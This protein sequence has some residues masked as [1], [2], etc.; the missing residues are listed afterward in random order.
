MLYI[1]NREKEILNMKKYHKM[2]ILTLVLVCIMSRVM[3]VRFE[4]RTNIEA[5]EERLPMYLMTEMPE[6]LYA[7]AE[8]SMKKEKI[9]W[10]TFGTAQEL[11]D[12]IVGKERAGKQ[13]EWVYYQ[14]ELQEDFHAL[15]LYH[16]LRRYER[17]AHPICAV[18]CAKGLF[19]RFSQKMERELIVKKNHLYGLVCSASSLRAMDSDDVQRLLD[20]FV[21]Y[22]QKWETNYLTGS[23]LDEE[24]LYWL[25]HD[26]RKTTYDKPKRTFTEMRAT[27]ADWRSRDVKTQKFGMLQKAEYEIAFPGKDAGLGI[28]FHYAEIIPETGYE[29]YLADYVCA[30]ENYV[31]RVTDLQT[32]R[33]IQI[34]DANLC[35]N[36]LDTVNF[37]DV[38]GDGYPDMIITR[39]V[40]FRD[41][42]QDGEAFENAVCILWNP[43]ENNFETGTKKQ[44]QEQKSMYAPVRVLPENANREDYCILTDAQGEQ[45]ILKDTETR[46]YVEDGRSVYIAKPQIIEAQRFS[47]DIG[48]IFTPHPYIEVYSIPRINKMGENALTQDWEHFVNELTRCSD[49]CKGRVYHLNFEKYH[50]DNGSDLYGYTFD[51]DAY[52][53]IYEVAVF[54][55]LEKVNML[56][57]IGFR[58][59]AGNDVLKDVTRYIG[60]SFIDFGGYA[61][62]GYCRMSDFAGADE[63][64]YPELH[65]MFSWAMDTFY[66]YA[67]LPDENYPNDHAVAFEE[68]KM[69]RAIRNA[70]GELWQL[71]EKERSL[72]ENRSLMMSD[73]AVITE[74]KC[75][76]TAG[77]SSVLKIYI[78]QWM[79]EI[80]LEKEE[81]FS[82]RDLANLSGL[83]KLEMEISG[84]AD[85]S[86]AGKLP[87]LRELRIVTDE[88]VDQVDFLGKLTNLRTLKLISS[89]Y[90]G[91]YKITDLSMLGN[92]RQLAYLYLCTPNVT[93]FSFLENTPEI[94]SI[95]LDGKE[96]AVP[97][98]DLLPNAM[99]IN[100]Y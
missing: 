62:D 77:V 84:L 34:A 16:A 52:D 32:G 29:T 80:D 97:D 89:S 40:H 91:F 28:S 27:D 2:M 48:F 86:F 65:N 12:Y 33:L 39:P 5:L 51:F 98:R 47:G 88:Q 71:D 15:D 85:Y 8:I 37:Q 19:Y 75:V 20:A 50:L 25:D 83:K 18:T 26:S 53:K 95:V 61:F 60:A 54:I 4:N 46:Q 63:W 23:A 90:I 41:S 43:V 44:T 36:S 93:D 6:N 45:Y 69:E 78:N 76:R 94:Y 38:N 99:Y 73:L 66:T 92:C 81:A 82:Y 14:C 22:P 21:Q 58:E 59:K 30:D 79:K 13:A 68:P 3:F 11:Q 9:S 87:A 67:E 64:D 72:F 57:T 55:R 24:A 42:E 31:M 35:I 100:F 10:K 1:Q 7:C 74:V 49:L 70:L 96:G 17:A 56:E